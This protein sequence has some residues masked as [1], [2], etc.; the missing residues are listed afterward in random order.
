MAVTS[1]AFK[2]QIANRNFLAPTG[3]KFSLTRAPKLSYFTNSANVPGISLGVAEQGSYLKMIPV[4][5]DM[6]E[7]NDLSIR[8]L[9]D[10]DLGNYLEIQN[11]MRG[12]GFPES[13]S[14]IYDLQ[15]EDNLLGQPYTENQQNHYSDGTLQI[16][17]NTE[18]LNYNVVFKDMFPTSLSD[19]EFDSTDTDIQY[20]SATVTFKYSIYTINNR[21]NKRV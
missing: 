15:N 16:L 6:M 7:F 5:G 14:E 2:K 10:E 13:L 3:F 20:F 9:V 12:L 11:W 21:F 8:F 18:N 17:T 1:L 4:P 19:M